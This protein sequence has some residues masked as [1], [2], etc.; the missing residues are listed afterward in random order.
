MATKK[1]KELR[2]LSNEELI[3]M[4]DDLSK[5]LLNIRFQSRIERPKNP[6]EKRET[7]K[8]IARINTILREREI[9]NEKKQVPTN[10]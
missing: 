4:R 8:T 7:R 6:M 2:E 9:L 10:K 1:T 3:K 5:K